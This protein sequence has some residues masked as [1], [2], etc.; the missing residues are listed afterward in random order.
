MTYQQGELKAYKGNK[1]LDMKEI[2]KFFS[3]PDNDLNTAAGSQS[4]LPNKLPASKVICGDA[5]EV[6]SKLPSENK[7][8]VIIA[9]PTL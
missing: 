1:R 4:L 5:L 7:F 6:L 2:I 3:K 9:D 8:E